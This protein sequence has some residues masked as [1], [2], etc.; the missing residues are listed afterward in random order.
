MFQLYTQR[1]S[2]SDSFKRTATVHKKEEVRKTIL[3]SNV[4]LGS[5]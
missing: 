2:N 5:R 4:C 1:S 3:L